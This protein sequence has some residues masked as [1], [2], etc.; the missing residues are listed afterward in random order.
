MIPKELMY[1]IFYYLEN[2][3]VYKLRLLNKH[4]KKMAY[5]PWFFNYIKYRPHPIIFNQF[6]NYCNIC[7]TTISFFSDYKVSRCSHH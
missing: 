6:D 2:Q 5:N 4:C 1:Y 7:N 3:D